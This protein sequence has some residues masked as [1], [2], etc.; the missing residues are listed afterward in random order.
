MCRPADKSGCSSRSR[1]DAGF[2][3]VEVMICTLVL[4]TGMTA[5]AGLLAYS[6]QMQIGAREA[7]RSMRL[8]QSRVD[9]LMKSDF[10]TDAQIAVCADWNAC[11]D[12][13]IA[14]HFETA[15]DGLNGI[16][17][18]WAVNNGPTA[19]TRVVTVRVVNMRGQ[20]QRQTEVTSIVRDW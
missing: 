4:T 11:L 6:V 7:A 3:L 9:E 12:G 5:L 2:T 16:T 18:R 17:V 13:N 20:Q 19:D 10:S 15:P 8:A 1:R 14:N